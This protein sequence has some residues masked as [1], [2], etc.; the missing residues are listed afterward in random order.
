MKSDVQD[1]ALR[2][3]TWVWVAEISVESPLRAVKAGGI[4]ESWFFK[5][6]GI[7]RQW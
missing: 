5:I 1:L 7:H 6:K 2:S 3:F 4:T